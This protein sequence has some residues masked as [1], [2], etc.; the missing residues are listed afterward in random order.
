V[1]KLS[2]NRSGLAYAQPF[3]TAITCLFM[4]LRH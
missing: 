1:L 2:P 3:A 4:G